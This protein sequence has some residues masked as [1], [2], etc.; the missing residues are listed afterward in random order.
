MKEN[1]QVIIESMHVQDDGHTDDV[2][3]DQTANN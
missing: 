3:S 2:L 1:F